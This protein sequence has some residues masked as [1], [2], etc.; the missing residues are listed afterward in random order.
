MPSGAPPNGRILRIDLTKER[1]WVDHPPQAFFYQ[2]LGGAIGAYYLSTL[3]PAGIDPLGPENVLSFIPG[4][5][6]H[7]AA[8]AFSRLAIT[9][10]SPLTG[11]IIDAQAGG[12]WGPEC[13]MAGFDAV[14]IQGRAAHPVYI[15][16]KDGE[17]QIR[18]ASTLWGL[19]TGPAEDR[20]K[21][22]E[23]DNRLRTCIIG[24]AGENL[25]RFANIANNLRHF[26]GR[27][28]LGAVMGSKNLKAIAVRSTQ[29]TM[30]QLHD[31]ERTLALLRQINQSYAE[32]EFFKLVL[33]PHGTPWAIWYNQS[34]GCLPTRNFEAG[35]FESA[36]H[37]DHNILASHPMSQASK[38]CFACRVRCK[39]SIE[40]DHE[41]IRIEKRY[42]GA[43][44]ET[45]GNLGPLLGI[46]DI[47]ALE[48]ANELCCKYTL[49]TIS[50]GATIA[51]AINCY[52][53]GLIT[54]K[55]SG[56]LELR[57]GDAPG[58]LELIEKIAYRKGFGDLLAEGSQRA[59]RHFGSEA[60]TLA[61]HNKGLEWPAVDPRLDP[62]QAIAYA[63]SPIGA[64]H[65]TMA[66][67]DCGPEFWEMDP[68]DNNEELSERLVVSYYLQRTG[69]SLID[70]LGICRFLAGATGLKRTLEIIN[71]AS[72]WETSL[73][74]LMRAGDRRVNLFRAYNAREG[75]TI[76]H[77]GMPQ[78]A[79]L[80]L[81]GGP[82]EGAHLDHERH[83]QA[84]RSYYEI[85]GWDAKS[86]WPRRGKL[87]ELGLAW[88][89]D[90]EMPRPFEVEK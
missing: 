72:G 7:L 40:Y 36:D 57:W 76:E 6:A 65:M 2:Y 8:G 64:D 73:W 14:V 56:G 79:Y 16:I 47:V 66:G 43:E 35:V 4:F 9:A 21:S 5:L 12:Y 51:W 19:E 54:G 90:E 44:Y 50:L 83:A 59:A 41:G 53:R 82:Q 78:R 85:S 71:A 52:Q 3:S 49:D 48:K 1:A 69:G 28:G 37:I 13:R 81:Q 24:P 18:D 25:V 42:G 30:P 10:K 67:P 74:E 46:D 61:A 11:A 22:Q 77:D 17:A 63:V 38:N 87:L 84:I 88:M 27:G 32:D 29:A 20:I 55:D 15:F 31:R 34:K 45:L 39:R 80:P 33:T 75:L 70:G 58:L 60:E 89:V 86:G 23:G 68:P 62:M 26:A